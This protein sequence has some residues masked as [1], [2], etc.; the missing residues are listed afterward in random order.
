MIS[1][2]IS[3]FSDVMILA[4]GGGEGMVALMEIDFRGKRDVRG[5]GVGGWM[6]GGL[7]SALM[8]THSRLVSHGITCNL[9]NLP[10]A[11]QENMK[12]YDE[13]VK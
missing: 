10:K 8:M 11:H 12:Y 2:S 13:I 3:L 1:S 7:I 5:W 9:L 6:G 4:V